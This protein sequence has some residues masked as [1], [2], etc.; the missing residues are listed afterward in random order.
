[1]WI[2][3]N[4]SHNLVRPW[5]FKYSVATYMWQYCRAPSSLSLIIDFCHGRYPIT[6][7][8]ATANRF[9]EQEPDRSL[10]RPAASPERRSHAESLAH[11]R[12]SSRVT[13]YAFR[14]QLLCP[15]GVSG[16]VLP[17]RVHPRSGYRNIRLARLR[18]KCTRVALRD[19]RYDFLR[20]VVGPYT[21]LHRPSRLATKRRR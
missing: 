11:A 13:A 8:L 4:Y 16:Y 7:C 10:N 3:A 14:P 17:R 15:A 1:M 9:R 2:L 6:L 19:S 12:R 5:T 21:Q 20:C 18:H